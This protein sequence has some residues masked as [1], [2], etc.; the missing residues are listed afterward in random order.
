MTT[1]RKFSLFLVL[2]LA[3]AA[4]ASKPA[5][6][7]A[8]PV[9]EPPPPAKIKTD[10]LI[11][12]QVAILRAGQEAFDYAGEAPEA[13]QLVASARM[14][15]VEGDCAYR[16]NGI[17]IKFTLHMGAKRGPRLGGDRVSFPFFM[18]VVDPKENILTRE[19]MTAEFKFSGKEDVALA[20]QALH[21]FIPLSEAELISGPAYRVLAAFPQRAEQKAVPPRKK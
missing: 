1:F 14:Q 13:A 9:D 21:V 17:D 3:L 18:A 12:P 7:K 4:C 10:N 2:G 11:C 16:E 20:E 15:T 19:T 8:E 6:E 5:E